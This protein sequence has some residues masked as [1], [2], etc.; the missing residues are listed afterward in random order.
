[1]AWEIALRAGA[2]LG[3]GPVWD[4]ARQRLLWV[5]ILS[6]AVHAYDPSTG[7]DTARTTPSHV[8]AVRP[9]RSGGLVVNLVDGIGLYAAD[10]AFSMLASFGV[11]GVRGNDATVDAT[12]ALWAGT[13]RYDE[14]PGG[15]RL[16]RVSPSGAVT[17]ILERVTISNGLGWSP[18]G[19]RMYYIDTPTHRI[20]VFDVGPELTDLRDRRPFAVVDGLPDGL[21][22]DTA[23]CVWAAIWEGGRVI[24]FTPS[25]TVDQVIELPVSRTTACAFA[26]PTLTDLYV[27]TASGTGDPDE[28]A[29]FVIPDAAQ[30]LPTHPFAG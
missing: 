24:R 28:G 25:G 11:E 9:R 27:T 18:D 26:G 1:M 12:G 22:V 10:G 13:M 4:A 21:T 5:D 16:Y 6:S 14:A 29:L 23:G 17:T 8:G 2:L 30:G 20:D 7:A 3:E 15:G 19:R